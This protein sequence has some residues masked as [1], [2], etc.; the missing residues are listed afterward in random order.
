VE[1]KQLAKNIQKIYIIKFF[2][3]FLVLMPVIVPFFQSIG[4]GMKGVY[5]LQSVFAGSVFLL[6]IPSGYISDLLGRKQT[7]II[8]FILKGIGF[9]LFPFAT[10]IKILII[11]EVILA[12]AVSLSSGTDTALIYDTLDITSPKKA[13]VKV[14]GRSLSY[15]AMGE[16][17]AA[18]LSS[19]LLIFSISI[20]DLAIISAATSWLTLF[21][22]FTLIEPPRK[23]ME[24]KHRENFKYIYRKLFK[25]SKLL[26]FI[27][28]N[29]ISSFSGTLFAVWLFQKYWTNLKIPL[30][31]FGFLW[32]I[33]NF[34]VSYTSAKAHQIEKSWGSTNILILIGILP[35]AGYLGIS[36]VDHVL[37]FFVC[38]LFQ[39]CRG[40]GQVILKDALNKRVTGDFRATANSVSQ[41]GVRVF[42]TFAGPLIGYFIDSR[43]LPLTSSCLSVFY[44]FVFFFIMVPLLKERKNF[45]KI[46]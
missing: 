2:T 43:G 23:K 5:L 19:I 28:L 32:A 41:M 16:G 1:N 20:K 44:I 4:I 26:N 22:A 3:M 42:F 9:S 27:I 15:F 33:T 38:L 17:V 11:A 7:L 29:I 10:D 34:V 6:E 13:K 12:I 30:M 31:Y 18:L 36:F 25:Q 8:S 39:V 14:L 24:N 40:F 21:I 37:G 46:K 35:I 45:I